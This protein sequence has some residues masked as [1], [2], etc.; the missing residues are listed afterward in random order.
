M[1]SRL[2]NNLGLLSSGFP[3]TEVQMGQQGDLDNLPKPIMVCAVL[4]QVLNK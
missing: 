4:T 1:E 2:G 3:R